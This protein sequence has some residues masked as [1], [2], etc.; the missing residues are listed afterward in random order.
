MLVTLIVTSQLVTNGYY[1]TMPVQN[2]ATTKESSTGQRCWRQS[3]TISSNP[4][5][6]FLSTTQWPHYSKLYCLGN[7]W[8]STQASICSFVKWEYM[9]H[10]LIL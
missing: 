4:A 5:S 2:T 9:N 6:G 1:Q 3:L 8:L 7:I 10:I